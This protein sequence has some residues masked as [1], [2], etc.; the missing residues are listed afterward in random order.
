MTRLIAAALAALWSCAAAAAPAAT[1]DPYDSAIFPDR[2]EEILGEDAV[3][4]HDARVIV[5]APASAEDPFNVPVM[6]DA[7][8][9]EGVEEIRV[10]VDWAPIPHILSYHPERALPRLSLRFKIDQATPVRAAARTADGVW[11]VGSTQID[12]A[13]GGCTAPAVAYASDDWEEKLGQVNGRLWP[14][15]GRLRMVVDHP[16]D[17]GL[18]DGI[19]VYIIETLALHGPDGARLARLELHEPVNEDPAFTLHFAPGT[20]P[21][22][23][24]LSGRDNG[25]AEIRALL[26]GAPTE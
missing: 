12:A 26:V 9:L 14:E 1:P 16:M 24:Q 13:G 8:A 20:L 21:D 3:L 5:R 15:A 19:P 4:V 11:H 10:F 2:V 23:V 22:S 6:V 17:T 25:G 7:S 18:A